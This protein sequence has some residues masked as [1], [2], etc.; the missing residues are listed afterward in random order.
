MK[1]QCLTGI[2]FILLTL[3]F[4]VLAQ[5][6]TQKEMEEM[7][8]AM[9]KMKADPAMMDAMKKAGIDMN[10]AENSMKQVETNG[11]GNYYEIGEF[12]MP[13]KD[14]AR[15]A[16]LSRKPFSNSELT[17]HLLKAEKRVTAALTPSD[18]KIA[19]L[20]YAKARVSADSLSGIANG[21]WVT[22]NY[23]VGLYMMGKA[24]QKDPNPDNLNNY[25]A[26]L[27]MTGG[28]EL[29]LPILQKLNREFPKNSTVLNNMGQAWF[30]LGD[31]AKANQYM[32]T[33]VMIYSYHPQA[34]LTQCLIKQS[35]GDKTGAVQSL[36]NSTRG[37]YSHEKEAMLRKLGYKVSG[38]DLDDN[39]HLPQDPLGFDKWLTAMPPF[40]L[41]LQEQI[42]VEPAWKAFHIEV[43]NERNKLEEKLA[44][45]INDVNRK[46]TDSKTGKV[47]PA[48]V[49]AMSKPPYL[50]A[51]ASHILKY[52]LGDKGGRNSYQS[53]QLGELSVK[54]EQGSKQAEASYAEVEKAVQKKIDATTGEGRSNDYDPCPELVRGHN[55]MIEKINGSYEEFM[56]LWLEIL[57]TRSEAAGYYYQYQ[58]SDESM[59]EQTELGLKI[60]FLKFLSGV[61][62]R[63]A[64]LNLIGCVEGTPE[65]G[66]RKLQD[67]NDLHCDR[68]VTYKVPLTGTMKFTCNT[69]EWKLS[70][71]L[72][73]FEAEFKQNLE[74]GEWISASAAVSVKAV[75]AGGSY[76]FTTGK[77]NMEVGA[78]MTISEDKLGPLPVK[79]SAFGG[80]TIEFDKDGISDFGLNGKL[81][82][83]VS[84]GSG[85]EDIDIDPVEMK[86]GAESRWSWNAGPSGVAK[87]A[88]DSPLIEVLKN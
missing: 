24:C 23:R 15:I 77:G 21:M 63:F 40:P 75:K 11:L 39:L 13:K 1:N 74:T 25:A 76:D 87:G 55:V 44:R 61:K 70:P 58:V 79:I 49:I 35:K 52:Y 73:P 62:P 81:E 51:K 83:K 12:M 3:P 2:V 36:K 85:S 20:L 60:D 37:G 9:E 86:I 4:T 50:S 68:L 43:V 54:Y 80:A 56:K 14:A 67:W 82:G 64:P 78:G 26:F 46:Y 42:R 41:S 47:D 22:G 45:L 27:V 32:D 31:L 6:P 69:T 59:I 38:K 30:G 57:T 10:Q 65:E 72:L 19:D 28:E 84:M 18:K 88:L 16:S 17:A 66:I 33:V 7:R 48:K 71:L 5:Q 29:A 34:N 53:K 8:K